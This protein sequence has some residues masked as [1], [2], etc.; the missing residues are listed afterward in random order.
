[1]TIKSKIH[2]LA[3][4][5]DQSKKAMCP[6][7][8][9]GKEETYS[10]LPC[11]KGELLVDHL[12]E[13]SHD[14]VLFDPLPF[15]NIRFIF[16]IEAQNIGVQ[17]WTPWVMPQTTSLLRY[18]AI[19]IHPLPPSYFKFFSFCLLKRAFSLLMLST[20]IRSL[21]V[22]R[23]VLNFF[24]II[25]IFVSF[26]QSTITQNTYKRSVFTY[27]RF[28]TTYK[29]SRSADPL[30]TTPDSYNRK[31]EFIVTTKARIYPRKKY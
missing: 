29:A 8:L 10:G 19:P 6:T 4:Q 5:T 27:Q 17:S 23:R 16:S 7:H 2:P 25:W 21:C 12:K 31:K 18:E 3:R 28:P 15:S 26:P 13:T 1:M 9:T 20:M 14:M 30:K 24:Y 11:E 22:S